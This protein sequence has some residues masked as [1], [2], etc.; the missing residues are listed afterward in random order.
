MI[1]WRRAAWPSPLPLNAHP[2]MLSTI[3]STNPMPA[4]STASATESYSSQCREW[5]SITFIPFERRSVPQM[6]YLTSAV[7][8]IT[9]TASENL[10]INIYRT[11]VSGVFRRKDSGFAVCGGKPASV[12]QFV[13]G[14]RHGRSFKQE[15][16]E[17]DSASGFAARLNSSP[18][19]CSDNAVQKIQRPEP[20]ADVE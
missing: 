1:A 10:L 3:N 5:E 19:R 4:S 7:R 11:P 8:S 18:H 14:I 15:H 13:A 2:Q 6:G 12:S 20:E 9:L 16:D 17:H